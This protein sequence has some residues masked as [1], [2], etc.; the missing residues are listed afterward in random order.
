VSKAKPQVESF[1]DPAT[2]TFTHVV[3]D[4]VGGHAAIIDPVLDFD[5]SNGRTAHVQADRVVAFVRAQSLNVDWVLET[6]AHADHLSAAPYLA[7]Q[8][9]GRVAVG[10]RI[11]QVQAIFKG[12]FHLEHEFVTDGS[13]FD[14][15]FSDGELFRIG[16]LTASA[17]HVPG[18][19]PADMAYAIGDAVFVGDTLFPPDVGTARC[20]FPGGDAQALYISIKRLLS[21]PEATRLFMC[22]DYPSTDRQPVAMTTVGE[23]RQRNIHVH[24]GITEGDFVSLRQARDKGLAAPRLLLPSVQVNIRAGH[25]PPPEA[26]GQRYLKIPVNVI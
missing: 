22:H 14:H 26:N 1:F 18:H 17:W 13:Q 12:V 9:G 24:D 7:S 2:F 11:T 4:Q 6:H 8:L 21:L 20:D 3:Y 23:Q 16:S 5:P 15:L 19:T 10:E 25:L